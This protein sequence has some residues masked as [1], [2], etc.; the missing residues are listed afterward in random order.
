M[1]SPTSDF[2]GTGHQRI[3]ESP[4]VEDESGNRSSGS[5]PYH[6]ASGSGYKEIDPYCSAIK[7]ILGSTEEDNVVKF[8]KLFTARFGITCQL[9]SDKK[10]LSTLTR[11]DELTERDWMYLTLKHFNAYGGF[12]V[13]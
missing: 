10:L 4:S 11:S 1:S 2:L 6:R 9:R 5:D 13:E 12:P 7:R 3:D 8:E